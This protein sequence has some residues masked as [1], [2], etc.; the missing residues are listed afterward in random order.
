MNLLKRLLPRLLLFVAYLLC[1]YW[2]LGDPYDL[3][4]SEFTGGWLTGRLLSLNF[5]GFFL[6][7]GAALLVLVFPRISAV[8]AIVACFLCLP[9]YLYF[10]FPRMFRLIFRGEW[11]VPLLPPYFVADKWAI[12]SIVTLVL[13]ASL[14]VYILRRRENKTLPGQSAP[15]GKSNAPRASAV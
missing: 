12:E 11:S 3:A 1:A 2:V 5:A 4:G 13:A 15:G 9:L 6:F 10:V 7:A 8:T 14:S